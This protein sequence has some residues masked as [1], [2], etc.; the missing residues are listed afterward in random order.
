M[1]SRRTVQKILNTKEI[2][3]HLRHKCELES[4]YSKHPKIGE[5][6][7]SIAN[8]F[9]LA[10][11]FNERINRFY[12][13]NNDLTDF[14]V[15]K[16]MKNIERVLKAYGFTNAGVRSFLHTNGELSIGYP[17]D[18][19]IRLA[20]FS[21]ANLLEEVLFYQPRY[22]GNS[23]SKLRVTTEELYALARKN[24]F[25]FTLADVDELEKES[26]KEKDSLV[27]KFPLSAD[28]SSFLKEDLNEFIDGKNANRC[29][30][31][32]LMG[33]LMSYGYSF[34][35]VCDYM[36]DNKQISI[37]NPYDLVARLAIFEKAN[38]FEEVLFHNRKYIENTYSKY[39]V[40]TKELFAYAIKN[41]YSFDLK[42]IDKFEEQSANYKE[43]L[44]KKYPLTPEIIYMLT[45]DLKEYLDMIKEFNGEKSLKLT[46]EGSK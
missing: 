24:N 34:D 26:R 21:K 40:P 19:A 42:D 3:K 10:G 46:R 33:L 16:N 4:K 8:E 17:E 7:S 11:S 32:N 36:D 22:M 37:A 1:P 18:F 12:I 45:E 15:Y 5:E 28:A 13:D 2:Q 9:G 38:L 30:E 14:S 27:K 43:S 41:N 20:I 6:L 23:Y 35:D 25:S 29:R 44:V 39:I 31:Y